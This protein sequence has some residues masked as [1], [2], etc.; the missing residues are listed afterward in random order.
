[1]EKTATLS[2]LLKVK[3]RKYLTGCLKNL[4]SL[5]LLSQSQIALSGAQ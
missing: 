2:K 5:D 4:V 1:M 3:V